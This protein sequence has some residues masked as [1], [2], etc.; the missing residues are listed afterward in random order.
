MKCPTEIHQRPREAEIASC[1]LMPL[2]PPNKN[3][4]RRHRAQSLQNKKSLSST[5]IRMRP[6]MRGWRPPCRIVRELSLCA[7]F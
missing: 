7:L 2:I 5:W 3:T 1:G 4:A 6:R